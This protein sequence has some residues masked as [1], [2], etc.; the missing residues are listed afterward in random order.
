MLVGAGRATS[1]FRTARLFRQ[2]K[3]RSGSKTSHEENRFSFSRS[4]ATFHSNQLAKK[5]QIENSLAKKKARAD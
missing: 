5:T 2:D 4:L 3:E 1:A